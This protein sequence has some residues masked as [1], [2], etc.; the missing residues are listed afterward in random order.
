MKKNAIINFVKTKIIPVWITLVSL[1]TTLAFKKGDLIELQAF[2]NARTSASFTKSSKNISATLSKGTTGEVLETQQLPSGNIAL[3]IK[4]ESGP[5]AGE[6]YWVYHNLKKSFISLYNKKSEEITDSNLL[7]VQKARLKESIS[8]IRAP[9]ESAIIEAAETAKTILDNKNVTALVVN[10][11]IPDCKSTTIIEKVPEAKYDETQVVEPYREVAE[12]SYSTHSCR[13]TKGGWDLCRNEKGIVGFTLVNHGPNKIVKTN[14]SHINREMSFE[15]EDRARSDMRL[16]VA[17]AP[18]D[19]VSHITYSIMM[20]FPRT[21]LPSVKKVGEELE[22]TL[23]TKEII[24]YNAKTKEVI[25]G[26]MTEGAM[27]QDPKNKNKAVPAAL[28]YTGRGVLI[29]AD[30]SGDLPYGDIETKSGA[31]A[32][33]ISIA[34]VSKKGFK[35]CKIPSKDIWYTDYNNSGNVLIKKDLATDAG[36]DSF[37]K[38]KCGF[39]IY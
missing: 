10:V 36:L 35:D 13:E 6:S 34:T 39:S 14:E 11:E 22:V 27:K 5:R 4:V 32:P 28:N 30:K 17:E 8:A 1:L 2:V 24:R 21:V 9:E 25:G 7:A 16:I 33:S 15:F 12:S 3:K 38:F 29:R 23:P 19:T 18:D 20:F 31:P 26:V 37:I